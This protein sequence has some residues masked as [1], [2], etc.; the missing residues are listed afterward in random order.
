MRT[1]LMSPIKIPHYYVFENYFTDYLDAENYC[2]ENLIPY[3]FI[4]KTY[5]IIGV[6]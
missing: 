5:Y 4:V 6:K 1:F 3:D 2:D